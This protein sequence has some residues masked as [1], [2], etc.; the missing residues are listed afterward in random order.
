MDRKAWAWVLYDWANSAYATVVMAGFFPIAFKTHF[1]SGIDAAQS[2]A[3]LGYANAASS[4]LIISLLP[5]LGAVADAGRLKKAFLLLFALVGILATAALGWIDGGEWMLA[6]GVYLLSLVG[7][8]GANAFYDAF[9]SDVA[10]TSKLERI[11]GYGFALGYLGGGLVF[12]LAVV[13]MQ[14]PQSFGLTTLQA[15]KTAFWMTAAWWGL[16]SIPLWLWVRESGK[17]RDQTGP[18]LMRVGW[19][20]LRATFQRLRSYKTLFLFLVAYWFY[21]DGVDTVIRM[22]VDYGLSLGFDQKDLIAALLLIQFVAFPGT[23][24]VVRFGERIGTKR[25]LLALIVI[26][27][28]IIIGASVMQT[29]THFFAL[30]ALIA[31]AQGGIQSLSRAYY[32]RMVPE[33][34]HGEFFGLYNMIGKFAAVLGPMMMAVVVQLSGDHRLAILSITLLFIIGFWLLLKVD[35]AAR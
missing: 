17:A 7:F 5:F 6:L 9:L 18:S 11:S 1:A 26:Y 25:T 28:L 22:A 19:Q 13:M 14:S 27:I 24:I 3:A 31:L 30:A 35:G 20:R 4:I 8:F 21:I 32:A 34:Y 15:L 29:K 2:T 23:I 16:F 33:G 10:P 12:L